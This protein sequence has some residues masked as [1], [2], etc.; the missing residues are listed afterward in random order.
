M[1]RTLC[2]FCELLSL[3]H[4]SPNC[5][6]LT[7][8]S[9][10]IA[11][12]P[13]RAGDIPRVPPSS[14][15]V[16]DN[17]TWQATQLD[18]SI[19]YH[20]APLNLIMNNEKISTVIL[21]RCST[22]SLV[23]LLRTNRSINASVTAYI[24]KTYNI[25]RI[26]RRYFADPL[27]FRYLQ[28]YTGTVI[29]GST[30]LQFFDR[31]FYPESDLDIYAPKAWGKEVGHFLLHAGYV[32]VPSK[33][34]HPTFDSEMQQKQVVT[35][36]GTYGNFKGIAGVFNFAKVAPDSTML[37]V[38][39]MVAVR[40]PMDVIL[41]YHSSMS[42]LFPFVNTSLQDVYS[43]GDERHYFRESLLPIP[44]CYTR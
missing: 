27:S 18:T 36:T 33:S 17:S 19:A 6:G 34:Q 15:L 28:A 43:C 31:S 32:F 22:K 44:S 29:S 12:F 30:A 37:K 7:F 9:Y 5:S 24:E 1:F 42:A 41:R 3:N 39:L 35:A 21:N 38:Q 13:D 40:S 26:L 23:L 25:Y 10:S 8:V 16:S 4:D 14:F 20:H 11:V 2:N